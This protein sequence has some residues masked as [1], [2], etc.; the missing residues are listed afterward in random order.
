MSQSAIVLGAGMVGVSV[1]LH[2]RRRGHDVVLVDRRGPGEGASF[3]NGG[4]IQREAVYP[5]PFPRALAELRRIA[6]NRAVDVA[7]HPLALPGFVS[8]LL[9]YWWHSEPGRYLQAV[10]AYARLITTCIDEHL[11]LA[12]GTEAMALLRPTGWMRLYSRPQMLEDALAQAEQAR[13]DYGVNFAALDGKALA[14][15]EPHLL[16]ER[17]GAI[18]WTDPLAV[19]DPHALTLAYAGLFTRDGGSIAVGDAM[20]LERAGKGWRVRTAEGAVEAGEVVIALGAA[21][22]EVTRR[23]GYAPPLF[24][25]RGYHM[26]YRLRGN[27][28]LNHPVLDTESGFLLAPMRAGIRLTTGAEFARTGA[29]PTPVQLERAEPVARGLLPLADRVD[30]EPWMGVRPC[31]PDML[32]I[33]GRLPGQPGA[34]CAF[35]HAHQGLTLG[36]TTGRLLAEMMSGA[37]PGISPE[38]YRPERFQG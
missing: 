13:R 1:A 22:A 29:A 19:S 36:P 26:H 38:P 15:A 17:T 2:L 25:K 5:H 28:V 20:T 23:F 4:L 27:A 11:A 16:V 35:G 21:S 8:P 37:V 7:Y 33:I 9:R 34:W 30:A 24:G 31:T 6:R 12:A 18:H 10:Q 14:A 32:P 3:G